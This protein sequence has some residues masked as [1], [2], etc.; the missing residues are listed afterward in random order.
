MGQ[1]K[2][3]NLYKISVKYLTF[4]IIYSYNKS[5]EY[6]KTI[7]ISIQQHICPRRTKKVFNPTI[8]PSYRT[9]QNFVNRLIKIESQFKDE[10][11]NL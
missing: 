6:I 9:K 4:L 11:D 5:Y 10:E 1:N 2:L 3:N 8:T 7:R